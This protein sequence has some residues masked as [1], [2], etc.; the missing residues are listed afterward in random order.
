MPKSINSGP[1]EWDAEVYHRVSDIQFG[2]AM[3]VLDRLSLNGDELV[4]DAGCG[5]GRVTQALADRLP[6]GRIIAVDASSE[7]V[8]KAKQVLGPRADVR[9][10]D[11][12]RLEIEEQVDLV[13][14]NAVFHWIADHDELFG[15]LH[16]ALAPGGRLVAQCGGEG[17]VAALGAAIRAV[18]ETTI[19][20]EHLQGFPG[21]WNFA[22]AEE[23]EVRLRGAGFEE[24]RCWL[25][26]KRVTPEQ[27]REFLATVTLGP[28]LARL[29]D[30]RK[31][32]FVTD[33]MEKLEEPL[34]LDYVR[35]NIEARK[36]A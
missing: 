6:R 34:A 12:V 11:L 25:E 1:V 13:F 17:N 2:W 32:G 14:S 30:D 20:K 36:A 28:Q 19:Y 10:V 24:A 4:L 26:S 16:G 8:E 29:P 7:M 15:R 33:V 18:A 31:E 21:M 27:P 3:E 23:T 9:A 22:S 35:L 5:S